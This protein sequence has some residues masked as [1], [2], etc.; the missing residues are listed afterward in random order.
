MRNAAGKFDNLDPARHLALGIVKGLAMLGRNLC[1]QLIEIGSDQIAEIE[2][3]LRALG[4][5][6]AGPSGERCLGS[7]DGLA[8]LGP[9]CQWHRSCGGAGGRIEN[10]LLAPAGS[11]NFR[12]GDI[13]HQGHESI[14][15]IM[16]WFISGDCSRFSRNRKLWRRDLT[17]ASL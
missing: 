12:A 16:Q 15:Q 5:R 7:L 14:P 1:C 13:M 6:G 4:G 11:G 2:H 17:R 3:D 9:A 8:D 10:I